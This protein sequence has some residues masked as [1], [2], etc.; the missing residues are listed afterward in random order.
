MMCRSGGIHGR[1]DIRIV[2]ESSQTTDERRRFV[3][4]R[5]NCKRVIRREAVVDAR[6]D[7]IKRGRDIFDAHLSDEWYDYAS[8]FHLTLQ[9]IVVYDMLRIPERLFHGQVFLRHIDIMSRI[10]GIA[11]LFLFVRDGVPIVIN[12]HKKLITCG[13]VD[14]GA[15]DCPRRWRNGNKR[16]RPRYRIVAPIAVVVYTLYLSPDTAVSP[17][18]FF[19]TQTVKIFPH[20]KFF[21]PRTHP[22]NTAFQ[23]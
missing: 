11:R 5:R 22:Q 1:A 8:V 18:F 3:R 6:N 7:H 16:E 17:L 9:R 10:R 19:S 4:R 14:F 21:M 12:S 13:G 15:R 2:L 23:H 20:R